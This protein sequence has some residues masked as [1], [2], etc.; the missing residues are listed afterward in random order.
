M[1]DRVACIKGYRVGTTKFDQII[2]GMANNGILTGS[3]WKYEKEWKNQEYGQWG[4]KIVTN[5]SYVEYVGSCFLTRSLT[6]NTV[7][8]L[9][10]HGSYQDGI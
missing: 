1:E 7:P 3:F 6:P 10:L 5:V 4:E 8:S 2:N 9:S